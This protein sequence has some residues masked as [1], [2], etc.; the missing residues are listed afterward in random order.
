MADFLK[1]IVKY[2]IDEVSALAVAIE[3]NQYARE[4][5]VG[6]PRLANR[7]Q[8]LLHALTMPAPPGLILEFGV[9]SGATLTLIAK[10]KTG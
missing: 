3:C 4:H 6:L 9:F 8:H 10:S 5:M 1:G 2:N 7:N